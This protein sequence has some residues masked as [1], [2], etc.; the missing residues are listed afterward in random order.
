MKYHPVTAIYPGSFDPVTN[1]H[2]DI[3]QRS[4]DLFETVIPAI[5]INAEKKPLFTAE[6]RLDMLREACEKLSP[7]V[8]P[9]FFQGLL[10]DA[11]RKQGATVI[12]RG[13]RAVSDYEYELQMA[14]MN[15]TLAPELET[16]FL[17]PAQRYSFLSSR[18]VKEIFA[19]GADIEGFVPDHVAKRLTQ[20]FQAMK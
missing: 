11:A 20:R 6:E 5:L 18:L 7:R 16:V 10:I 8:E 4:L 17:V 9:I 12:I 2:L 3:I 19:H 15:R 14:L 13:I 1:G